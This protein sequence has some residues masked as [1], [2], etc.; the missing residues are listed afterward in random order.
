MLKSDFSLAAMIN[1]YSTKAIVLSLFIFLTCSSLQAQV[2][3]SNGNRMIASFGLTPD[4]LGWV[5]PDNSYTTGTKLEFDYVVFRSSSFG[6]LVDIDKLDQAYENVLLD[7]YDDDFQYGAK[8][9]DKSFQI[10][11]V[12]FE[13][14]YKHYPNGQIAP[15]GSYVKYSVGVLSVG[16]DFLLSDYQSTLYPIDNDPVEDVEIPLESRYSSAFFGIGF[17]E[18]YPVYENLYLDIGADIR[19][20]LSKNSLFKEIADEPVAED[21]ES[22]AEYKILSPAILNKTL[23]I[24][25]SLRYAF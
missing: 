3:G 11:P 20:F 17:G 8:S 18:S 2:S 9:S 13:L 24:S 21:V 16:H 7:V 19:V 1:R 10:K 5:F 12:L 4:V 25:I 23:N 14:H 6:L 22:L 15:M